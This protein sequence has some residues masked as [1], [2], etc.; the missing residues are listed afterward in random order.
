M[1]KIKKNT[2]KSDKI[3]SSAFNTIGTEPDTSFNN[4]PKHG[5]I[6]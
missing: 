4:L 6:S 1:D 2:G 5:K 3:S